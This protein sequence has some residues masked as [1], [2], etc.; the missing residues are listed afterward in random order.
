MRL[1]RLQVLLAQHPGDMLQRM[2]YELP[3]WG[4]NVCSHLITLT[5]RCIEAK[6]ICLLASRVKEEVH[7]E[8]GIEWRCFVDLIE[9]VFRELDAERI[10]HG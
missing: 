7:R 5:V 1:I 3:R 8:V 10:R 9:L 6:V 2:A 4:I